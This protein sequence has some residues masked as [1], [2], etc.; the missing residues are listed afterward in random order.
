MSPASWLLNGEGKKREQ[1]VVKS[2]ATPVTKQG[3]GCEGLHG[4]P[5]GEG[6]AYPAGV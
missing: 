5:E 3:V 1:E 2:Q 4:S 6:Q